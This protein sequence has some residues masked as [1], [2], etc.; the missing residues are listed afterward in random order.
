MPRFQIAGRVTF[1]LL[2]EVSMRS[3]IALILMLLGVFASTATAGQ[4][5]PVQPGM[6]LRVW[7]ENAPQ[8]RP[9]FDRTTGTLSSLTDETL[10]LTGNDGQLWQIPR[11]S[12]AWLETAQRQSRGRSAI[13]SAGTGLL[14]GFITGAAIGFLSGDDPEGFMAFS[15]EDKALIFGV[16]LAV[17]SAV[18]G[19]L[20][21]VARPRES[22]HRVP[23]PVAP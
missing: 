4:A 1:F 18:V 17:P 22:W 19:A 8:Q 5:D 20:I 11:P 23:L 12:I 7:T 14:A 6:R 2:P 13:R 3:R 21:G 15:A 10:F 16:G 9:R